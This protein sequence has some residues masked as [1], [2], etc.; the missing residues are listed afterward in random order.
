PLT[1]GNWNTAAAPL[2]SGCGSSA[3]L[4]L[5][6]WKSVAFMTLAGKHA[7]SFLKN[8]KTEKA[9]NGKRK[10]E[11]PRPIF[12]NFFYRNSPKIIYI[13][14]KDDLIFTKKIKKG[15]YMHMTEN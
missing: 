15:K 3:A 7:S 10:T 5:L 12:R 8:K 13:N 14:S 11:F 6:K 1:W 2:N 9:E 4:W